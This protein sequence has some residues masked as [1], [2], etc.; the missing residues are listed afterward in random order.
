[1]SEDAP[2]VEGQQAADLQDRL[3]L[4]VQEAADNHDKYLRALADSENMRKRLERLCEERIWQEKK[5]LLTHLLELGDQL[6]EALQ[7]AGADDPL[8]TG[9][10]L[11]YEQL[12]RT[13]DME[14]VQALVSVGKSFDPSLHEAVELADR[15]TTN[16]NQVTFEYRK[17]YLLDGKLLRAARVQVAREQ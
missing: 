1:M 7:Y 16:P 11:T 2:A 3:D 14:G 12:E 10:R 13:L 8:G 5:R 9:L 6:K 4:A 17:G 15:D